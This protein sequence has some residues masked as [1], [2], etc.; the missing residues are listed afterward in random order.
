[1]H[2]IALQ[3]SARRAAFAAAPKVLLF[4]L[5]PTQYDAHT[6]FFYAQSNATVGV[7]ASRTYAT[8]KPGALSFQALSTV[9]DVYWNVRVWISSVFD[10]A[11]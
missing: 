9:P 2:R 4:P 1:M 8:A 5:F 10:D 3:N 11:M 7:L 6:T